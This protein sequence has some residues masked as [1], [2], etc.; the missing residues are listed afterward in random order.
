MAGTDRD[1]SRGKIY[2]LCCLTSGLR[3]VGSTTQMYLS[4]R[5]AYHERDYRD[6]RE[7]RQ[8]YMT[9]YR[10]LEGNNYEMRLLETYPCRT[11]KELEAREQHYIRTL[12]CVN[13]VVPGRTRAEYRRDNREHILE[14]DRRYAAEHWDEIKAK[15]RER[16]TCP[17]CGKELSRG[18]L[19]RH[20]K[21]KSHARVDALSEGAEA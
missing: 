21:S 2:E 10:I 1:Y 15:K 11:E 13:K 6:W 4:Q 7:G 16:V 19:A 14:Y 12:E 3:Y 9:S 5:L 8:G 18:A 17:D 20:R